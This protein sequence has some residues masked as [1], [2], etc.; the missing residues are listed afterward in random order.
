MLP[1]QTEC[2][3][4]AECEKVAERK[5][6]TDTSKKKKPPRK[7]ISK[8]GGSS[9]WPTPGWIGLTVI[10]SVW[11]FVVG[12]MVG[13]GTIS[14]PFNFENTQKELYAQAEKADLIAQ[15]PGIVAEPDK[16]AASGTIKALKKKDRT[17]VPNKAPS[18][19]KTPPKR[20]K[21]KEPLRK[22]PEKVPPTKTTSAPKAK[23]KPAPA[24]PK[25]K[26][27]KQKPMA[28]SYETIQVAAMK[29]LADA[30]RMV[31][32]FRHKGYPAYLASAVVSGKGVIHRIRMGPLKGEAKAKDTLNR[33]K[34]QG[35][36]AVL[37][38]KR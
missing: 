36:D 22:V 13:R 37:L 19:E 5:K 29:N 32:Q 35:I 31:A 20:L 26:K 17:A 3:K 28:L 33:L 25:P 2:R 10:V 16:K 18:T 11:M 23:D 1:P 7:K 6:M 4:V 24:R 38:G 12:V 30:K 27:S 14:S 21:K 8:P 15:K 9:S 34:K